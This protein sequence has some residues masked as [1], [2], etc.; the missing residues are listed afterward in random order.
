M[1]D[2]SGAEAV[3]RV[4]GSEERLVRRADSP[5]DVCSRWSHQCEYSSGLDWWFGS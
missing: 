1:V 3:R 5:V 2:W 4:V